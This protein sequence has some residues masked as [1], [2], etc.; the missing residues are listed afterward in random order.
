M[1]FKKIDAVWAFCLMGMI[2]MPQPF[3][4]A[5]QVVAAD[6]A[7]YKATQDESG[8]LYLDFKGTQLINVLNSLSE[9]S[10]INFVAGKEIASREV[11]L[12]LDG[13][14]L[15][16][17]LQAIAQGSNV[18]YA[19]LPDTNI[20]MFRASSDSPSLAPLLTRV[21]K[22][23]FLRASKIREIDAGQ[24]S[25]GGSGSSGSGGGLQSIGGSSKD[26]SGSTDS[27]NIPIL[28]I[29]EKMLSERGSVSVD[30]RSN[31]VIVTDTEDRLARVANVVAELDRPLNQVLIN[32]LLVETYEDL[33]HEFGIQWSGDFGTLTGGSASTKFPFSDG[34][35]YNPLGSLLKANTTQPLGAGAAFGAPTPANTFGSKDFSELTIQVKAL[36]TASKLHILAKPNVLVLD[37]QPAIIKIATN[38]A[39]GSQTV[40][41]ASSGGTATSTSSTQAE[42]AEVGTILRVTP[43]INSQDQITLTIEPTFATVDTSTLNID[44]SAVSQTGD[45]TVRSM[46]TTMMVNSGKTLVMGGL[47]FS[48]QSGG[49]TKVP[50]FGDLPVLGK[51]FTKDDKA[52]QDRELILF[53]TPQI[54]RNPANLETNSVPDRNDR[55]DNANAEFWK[56]KKKNW[57]KNMKNGMPQPPNSYDQYFKVRENA[58]DK[59]AEEIQKQKESAMKDEV[60]KTGQSTDGKWEVR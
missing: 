48:T 24:S 53:V 15:E 29:M 6:A 9:I 50:F 59:Q 5:Q 60:G 57:Y 49:D 38:A 22:L 39:I 11:N 14:S 16:Q 37:N 26:E 2:A 23:Y 10:K 19:Y 41:A 54:I 13:V 28:K 25:S 31:S 4:L 45:T 36:Q 47:L 44:T 21:F 3:L 1:N 46:R 35:K 27:Q 18:T 30:D 34:N 33:D 17:A 58:M 42:R 8:A 7:D 40:T 43:Q 55:F 56:Y 20:I 12:T 52:I 32:V 51:L